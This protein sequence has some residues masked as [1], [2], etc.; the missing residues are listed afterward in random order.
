MTDI[1]QYVEYINGLSNNAFSIFVGAGLSKACGLPDWQELITPYAIKLGLTDNNLPYSRIMQY[2]L[3]NKADYSFFLT[4]LKNANNRCAPRAVHRL[5]A[6]LNLPRIWTTNYDGILESAYEGECIPYQV[7][8]T[9]DDIYQLDYQRNQIIKMHGSLTENKTTDIVLLESEYENYIFYRSGIYQLLQNDIRT[10]TFLYFGFSFD[11]LNIRKVVAS[12][13]NQKELG[14]PS[15]LFT[16]PPTQP[17]KQKYYDCWKDDLAR[18]NIEVVELMD[19]AEIENFMF[20][21]LKARFGKTILLIGK[22][23]D[24]KQNDLAFCIGEKLAK[25]GYKIHSG[26]GPNIANAMAEGAWDYLER[27]NIPID[28]KVVFFYRFNGGSTNPCKGHISYCGNT[29]SEVRKRMIT[30]DK[31]CLVLGDEASEETGMEEEIQIARTKG[32]RIIPVGCSGD[33]TKRHWEAEK[34]NY[35]SGVFQDKCD[36]YNMLASTTCSKEQIADA[37]VELADYLLVRDYE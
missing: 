18:Y 23:N 37:V 5:I 16:V 28:D 34:H 31:I 15:F 24:T 9:D 2:A 14:R 1:Y 17:E 6:R 33:F 36:A 21:L 11:D 29:R 12:V 19:Y 10:K 7:V 25:S 26:G 30:S 35:T 8:S 27:N 22:R 4:K 3:K 13:W 20:S 32:A